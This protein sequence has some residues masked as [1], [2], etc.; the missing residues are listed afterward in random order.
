M[1]SRRGQLA[2]AA[3]FVIAALFT[4]AAWG[5]SLRVLIQHTPNKTVTNRTAR[6]I[7]DIVIHCT[8]GPFAGSVL[9]LRD[10][11]D[12]ASA[13]FV[14]SRT[15]Q[16]VQLVPVT[17]VAWH[18]GNAYWNLHSIGIE[19]VGYVERNVFTDAEYRASAELVA[20]LAHRWTI[21]IDRSHIIGH[22]EVP[23][24]DHPGEFGGVDHHTDPGPYWDWSYYMK[25][26]RY[27]AQHP[28]LPHFVKRITSTRSV[29]AP[30]VHPVTRTIVHATP[31]SATALPAARSTVAP[32]A[33]V[34]G[35]PLWWSGVDYDHRWSKHIYK[36]DF[37][38]DGKL[39]YTDH[40]WPYSFSRTKGW[41][42]RTVANG[43]HMLT[44]LEYGTGHYRVRKQIPIRVENV[45]LRVQVTGAVSDGAVAGELT[46]GVHVS[47]AA[48]RVVLYA[49]G[50]PVSRD[51]RGPFTLRWDTASVADG[52]H[53]LEVY[54]RDA[55]GHRAAL[56]VPVL[57]ANSGALPQAMTRNWVTGRVLAPD[58]LTAVDTD[59]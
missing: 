51:S 36:V 1:G 20:Y 10:P 7:N 39:L 54:A 15:G 3:G 42:S 52:P 47:Q 57:V 6:T 8:Q 43:R 28:V 25:L 38:V 35:S 21:P 29:S 26:V 48:E 18:S 58:N 9:A 5:A 56:T 44:E 33:V 49:D 2:L 32:G 27:Y 50:R 41:D 24:P 11:F 23:D 30:P 14:V 31:V 55:H 4:S 19:H 59:R 34:H 12:E 37:Y 17:D 22:S 40:T 16:I 45:P 46:L 13:H 53:T